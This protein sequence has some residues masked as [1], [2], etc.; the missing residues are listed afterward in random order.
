MRDR[1]QLISSYMLSTQVSDPAAARGQAVM[2]LGQTIEDHA[3]IAAYG[4][5]F[6]AV[7]AM[8]ILVA[9]LVILARHRKRRLARPDLRGQSTRVFDEYRAR[10]GLSSLHRSAASDA[11]ETI[12]LGPKLMASAALFVEPPLPRWH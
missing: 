8:L 3:S 1:F 10:R 5:V 2:A 9:C 4:G 12:G 11:P 7:G 6:A